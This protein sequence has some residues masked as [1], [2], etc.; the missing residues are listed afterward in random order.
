MAKKGRQINQVLGLKVTI[1][2]H[3]QLL[4]FLVKRLKTGRK[5]LAVTLNPEM[6]MAARSDPE[7]K[8]AI[9]RAEVVI[10]D[11]SGIVWALKRQGVKGA[12]RIA[13]TELMLELINKGY[14]AVFAGAGPGVAQKAAA[15]LKPTGIILVGMSEP[16][17][18][19]INRI[20]P[21]LLFVALGHGKQEKWLAKNLPR[22]QV[23]LAMGV[24]GALDQ[25]AK[26]WLRAPIFVR[27]VGLEWLYRLIVQPW[28]IKRQMALLEFAWKVLTS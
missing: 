25:I 28:R 2:R 10:P 5:T 16:N 26:P 11:G 27:S 1:T 19:Q 7:L 6:V 21:D 18:G 22:L 17:I 20:K 13:G 23:R 3:D 4:K 8:R 12:E 24:G 14:S 9:N 15:K